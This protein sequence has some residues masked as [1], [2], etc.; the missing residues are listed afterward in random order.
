MTPQEL[1]RPVE[2]R[3]YEENREKF[4]EEYPGRFVLIHG[5]ELIDTYE[6]MDE[7][8]DEGAK[9]FYPDPILVRE[10]GAETV[11]LTTHFLMLAG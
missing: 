7:A 2:L 8:L 5:A 6:T 11:E 9:R 1:E 10:A 4:L 3:F